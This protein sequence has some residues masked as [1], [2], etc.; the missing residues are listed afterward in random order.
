MLTRVAWLV[1]LGVV[2]G[3]AASA[4]AATLIASMLYGLAPRDPLTFAGG[5][6]TLIAVA[7]FAA[8]LP[9]YRAS[10]IDPAEI[11]REG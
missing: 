2:V 11:L 10:R 8:W 1:A 5:A 3:A 7:A 4:W 6:A 9:A